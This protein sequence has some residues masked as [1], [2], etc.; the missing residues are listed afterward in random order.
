MVFAVLSLRFGSFG[1][2][3]LPK[4]RVFQYSL[5]GRIFHIRVSFAVCERPLTTQP[6]CGSR[7]SLT[8][9]HQLENLSEN[10]KQTYAPEA[11]TFS[12]SLGTWLLGNLD[13]YPKQQP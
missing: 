11:T 9:N 10:S 13:N 4:R 7:V 12:E 2:R 8:L 5:K 1:Y 6:F 3:V